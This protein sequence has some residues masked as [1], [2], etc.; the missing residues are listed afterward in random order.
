MRCEVELVAAKLCGRTVPLSAPEGATS[1]KWVVVDSGGWVVA[2]SD[3]SSCTP[4]LT[5]KE[6]SAKGTGNIVLEL[7]VN[8]K[9]DSSHLVQITLV[10]KSP[11]ACS[12][13][14][15]ECEIL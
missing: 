10:V 9:T 11:T 7:F 6:G 5:V 13:A 8:G 12:A 3:P 1:C 2:L 14:P 4:T 15:A